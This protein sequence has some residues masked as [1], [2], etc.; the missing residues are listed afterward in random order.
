V[1]SV[2]VHYDRKTKIWLKRYES[3]VCFGILH[4]VNDGLLNSDN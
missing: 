1:F 2:N 4:L 3:V